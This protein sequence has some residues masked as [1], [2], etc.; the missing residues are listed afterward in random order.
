MP[1]APWVLDT[2]AAYNSPVLHPD[3]SPEQWDELFVSAPPLTWDD[4]ERLLAAAQ[5]ARVTWAEPLLIWPDAADARYALITYD[6]PDGSRRASPSEDIDFFTPPTEQA[7]WGDVIV[8]SLA[9]IREAG[10]RL[11]RIDLALQRLAAEAAATMASW[12]SERAG[13][14]AD[15]GLEADEQPEDASFLDDAIRP[16]EQGAMNVLQALAHLSAGRCPVCQLT[17]CDTKGDQ[18]IAVCRCGQRHTAHAPSGECTSFRAA[19]R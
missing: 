5:S 16:Y 18:P 15:E 17:E 7:T 9:D 14:L 13:L 19:T 4:L 1:Y 8:W 10:E 2:L 12:E 6:L 3:P 11:A